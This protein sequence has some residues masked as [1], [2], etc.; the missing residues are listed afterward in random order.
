MVV[1]GHRPEKTTEDASSAS[2]WRGAIG[3]PL[4]AAWTLENH[5]GYADAL[6]L[7]FRPTAREEPR[8]IQLHGAGS[9]VRIAVV[10]E[11][12]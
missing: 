1:S 2:P 12:N 6:Q 8:A 3:K 7:D 5:N 4:Y 11:T 9:T 10:V